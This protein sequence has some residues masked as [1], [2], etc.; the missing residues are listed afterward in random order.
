MPIRT[1]SSLLTAASVA[2]A[3]MLAPSVSMGDNRAATGPG[4]KTAPSTKKTR[5]T[6]IRKAHSTQRGRPGAAVSRKSLRKPM[7]RHAKAR[8]KVSRPA[9]SQAGSAAMASAL[10]R[11]VEGKTSQAADRKVAK[12]MQARGLSKAAAARVLKRIDGAASR[13]KRS[14][15]GAASTRSA[16]PNKDLDNAIAHSAISAGLPGALNLLPVIVLPPEGVAVPWSIKLKKTGLLT[17]HNDDDDGADELTTFAMVATPLSN[18][19]FKFSTVELGTAV[20]PVND[21]D[22]T[23]ATIYSGKKTDTLVVTTLIEDDGGN[24][25]AAREEIEVLVG[26][27]ASVAST[28]AG[29]DRLAILKTMIDYTIALDGVGADSSRAA[30]SVVST[31]ILQEEWAPLWS[32]DKKQTGAATW[33]LAIPHT[34]GAGAYELLLDVPSNLSMTT[35]RARIEAFKIHGGAPKDG[36]EYKS[37]IVRLGIGDRSHTFSI[38][39]STKSFRTVERKVIDGDVEIELSGHLTYRRVAP[40]PETASCISLPPGAELEAC[41]EN[42]KQFKPKILNSLDFVPGSGNEYSTI[43]ST[44][45]K[46]FKRA[47]SPKGGKPGATAATTSSAPKPLRKRSTRGSAKPWVDVTISARNY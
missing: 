35:I 32:A 46:G 38:D 47:T 43:Y 44:A 28:M 24:A 13:H 14:A 1:S 9:K 7:V 2:A 17:V 22:T 11:Y 15:F 30:R 21:L 6:A 12:G 45:A 8:A 41:M 3:L 19:D 10:R 25:V 29:A 4:G 34:V 39:L 40:I 31:M 36:Y 26:L 16:K 27:A 33:T 18:N 37:G 42:L 5:A 20:H 23:T